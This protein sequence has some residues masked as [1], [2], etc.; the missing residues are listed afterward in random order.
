MYT[1]HIQIYKKKP[2]RHKETH[3]SQAGK[4]LKLYAYES[5]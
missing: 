1:K 2:H 3:K 5:M 4:V